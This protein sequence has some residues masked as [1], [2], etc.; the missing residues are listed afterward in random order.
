MRAAVLQ[1]ANFLARELG[2]GQTF[3]TLDD[4]NAWL[5]QQRL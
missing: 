4:L 3:S 2:S 1:F 5:V